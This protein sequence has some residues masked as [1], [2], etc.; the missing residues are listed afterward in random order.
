M[1]ITHSLTTT[2]SVLCGHNTGT[3]LHRKEAIDESSFPATP[4]VTETSFSIIGLVQ[5]VQTH[6]TCLQPILAAIWLVKEK[7]FAIKS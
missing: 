1:L 4:E 2:A 7:Y 6:R 3:V 5:A